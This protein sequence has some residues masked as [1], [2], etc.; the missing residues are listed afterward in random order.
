MVWLKPDF[1][2]FIPLPLVETKG[3]DFEFSYLAL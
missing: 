1:F 3:N 2:L